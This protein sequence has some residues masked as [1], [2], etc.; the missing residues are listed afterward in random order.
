MLKRHKA[1]KKAWTHDPTSNEL[2][3]GMFIY[4]KLP[5]GP[6]VAWEGMHKDTTKHWEYALAAK[7][8]L[9]TV[10][11]VDDRM[12]KRGKMHEMYNKYWHAGNYM[13]CFE[14]F[15]P[16]LANT[17]QNIWI[18]DDYLDSCLDALAKDM[19]A[20]AKPKPEHL[21]SQAEWKKREIHSM[22][23]EMHVCETD[24]YEMVLKMYKVFKNHH[25]QHH[26]VPFQTAHIEVMANYMTLLKRIE[27]LE[28]IVRSSNE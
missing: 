11:L 6:G 17:Q 2:E 18:T 9:T 1:S 4:N 5:T 14:N 28:S 21:E 3:L 10:K 8:F 15:L 12:E 13:N 24:E 20:F 19:A 26:G 25:M 27:K 22:L 23:K 16:L 7:A